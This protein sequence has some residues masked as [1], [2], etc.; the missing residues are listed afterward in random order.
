V[1][2]FV[3]HLVEAD[4]LISEILRIRDIK[5]REL[6]QYHK[7]E[8]EHFRRPKNLSIEA[9]FQYMTLRRGIYDVEGWLAWADEVL[10]LLK[11]PLGRNRKKFETRLHTSS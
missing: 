6:E 3:G 11:G 2:L 1:K 9:R 4:L 8:N 10:V 5:A 7:I